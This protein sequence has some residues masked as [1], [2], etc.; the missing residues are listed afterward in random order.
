LVFV[1]SLLLV[2]GPMLKITMNH[3]YSAVIEISQIHMTT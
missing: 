1:L 3:N 2:P